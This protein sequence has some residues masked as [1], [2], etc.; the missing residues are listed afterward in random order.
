MHLVQGRGYYVI[1]FDATIM[2]DAPKIAPHAKTMEENLAALMDTD[3][4]NVN[5]KSTTLEGV[6]PIGRGEAIA[7]M[8][9]ALILKK[10]PVG[11]D[12][13]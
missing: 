3:T 1:N 7:A 8:A 12:T 6:G 4:D 2:A 5:V 9:T 13:P 10:S 11:R